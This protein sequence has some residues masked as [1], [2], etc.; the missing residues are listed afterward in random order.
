MVYILVGLYLDFLFSSIDQWMYD[1]M[2]ITVWSPLALYEVLK[3]V[4]VS[5]A[6][7]FVFLKSVLASLIRLSLLVLL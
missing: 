1:F 2:L 6:I 3:S 7:L 4:S 5:L